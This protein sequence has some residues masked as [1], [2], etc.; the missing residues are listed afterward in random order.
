ME[1]ETRS[2]S[3]ESKQE[4]KT[5]F[6]I[7]DILYRGQNRPFKAPERRELDRPEA[8]P[9]FPMP[10]DR[11]LPR[12]G[13][14]LHV[15]MGA[16][17]AY[18][19][20]PT[21]KAVETPYFLSQGVPYHALFTPSELS[22][23]ALKHCRRRKARTVFSD[24]QL[25]GLEKRFE[26]Q[27]YLSTPERVELAGALNLSETQVKT[28]FQ[29]R[30]M[31]H[32][33]QLRKQQQQRDIAKY[34]HVKDILKHYCEKSDQFC[35]LLRVIS[36]NMKYAA[37]LLVVLLA[38]V[39]AQESN[40]TSDNAPKESGICRVCVCK[41][42]TV[43]CYDNNLT[44][45]FSKD[46]WA[47]LTD[48]KPTHVDLSENLFTN[49]T[50]IA[51][52]SIEVLN[53][54][55]CNIEVIE[56][57]SFRD[58]QEMRV[59][60][61]S[62]NKLTSAKLSPHAFEGRFQPEEYKPLLAMRI[63]SL[64]YNDL[65]SLNQ[66]LFEH[67]AE[68]EELDLS[69]NPLTT[70]DHV[71]IIAISSLPMLKVLRLRSCQL[72]EI[73]DKMLHT[74]RYLERLDVSDNQ[75]TAVP[76][77]LDESKLLRY[78][79]LNQNPIVEFGFPRLRKLQELHMCNMPVLRK[80][81][82]SLHMSFNP[83]LSEIDPKALARA[84]DIGETYDWPLVKKIYLQSN[85]LTEIDSRLLSRWDLLEEVDVSD[86]PFSCDCST[87]W[88]VDIL[89]PI[90]EEKGSNSSLMVCKDPVEMQG[91]TMKHLHDSHRSM[92]C[93]DKYGHRPERDG[94]ILLG[95]LIGV[96]LAVPIMLGLML[97][98]RHG[99]FAWLGL[100]G[101]VDVSRAFYK[102]APAEESFY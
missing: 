42:G 102:R 62:H 70:I 54:S 74:P 45:F 12:E 48:F 55:R 52:L 24:P 51:D 32:K 18:L 78:L 80:I 75:L 84:D 39:S 25:T 4:T 35:A 44:T 68:L 50:M 72:T 33:K 7:E 64:A 79:N 16:L 96:L 71:T 77:E 20:A 41:D 5:S 28:W 81:G 98:W 43:N 99:Y 57:A 73:P 19:H 63:L 100:R 38:G 91:Y 11:P 85:N 93:L 6:L 23:S 89:V 40:S 59:L 61:L 37:V 65:H 97:M 49:V 21:Y 95:T 47:E 46:E 86:N 36:F 82:R 17:G 101:P 8:K 10:Q 2:D 1:H 58:L 3:P 15:A 14:Y 60:D 34:S 53:L 67:L 87:Q 92:R 69:G 30:R 22:L 13:S 94:A 26:S 9:F 56:N 90:V 29:N 83:S 27:R 88:M 76:Q 66:D 31:K